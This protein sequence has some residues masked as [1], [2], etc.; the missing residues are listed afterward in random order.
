MPKGF[1]S[2]LL[3]IGR[4]IVLLILFT[5]PT[6]SQP[7]AGEYSIGKTSGNDFST[8]LQAIDSLHLKGISA[9]VKF[10][11]EPGIY[12]N[13][14]TILNI[15]GS[16][17]SNTITFESKDYDSTKVI[18]EYRSVVSNSNFC[19]KLLGAK[20]ITFSRLTFRSL[21]DTFGRVII[22]T[23]NA[24]S[25]TFKNC[26][27]EG[28]RPAGD[29][30]HSSDLSIIFSPN[31]YKSN[32]DSCM[33]YCCSFHNGSC[34]LE[35]NGNNS[36]QTETGITIFNCYFENQ[37][38]SSLLLSMQS[39]LCIYENTF[40]NTKGD[41]FN[42][43]TIYTANKGLSI[44]S[45]NFL[46]T[47]CKSGN[48]IN[49]LN[50]GGNYKNK[51]I[52]YNNTISFF[53][54]D[55]IYL[56][57]ASHDAIKLYQCD[58]L[59][60]YYN[61]FYISGKNP[62]SNIVKIDQC[63][64]LI[65]KNNILF[66]DAYGKCLYFADS[67]SS[68]FLSDNN[69]FY[70]SDDNCFFL[71][72]QLSFN[73]WKIISKNDI[74][75]LYCNPDF[76]SK[77]NLQ[78]NSLLLNNKAQAV[79]FINTD[80]ASKIRNVLFPDIGA[81]EFNPLQN[82]LA[83][84]K[85]VYPGNYFNCI[86]EDSFQIYVSLTNK[87]LDTINSF[88][89]KVKVENPD[90]FFTFFYSKPLKSLD[91]IIVLCPAYIIPKPGRETNFIVI[92]NTVNDQFSVND[93]LI[94]RMIK[95]FEIKQFPFYENFEHGLSSYFILENNTESGISID[96][97]AANNSNYGLHFQGKRLSGGW[98]GSTSGTTSENAWN[99]NLKYQANATTCNIIPDKNKHLRLNINLRQ[100]YS[101][102][103]LNSWF[104]VMLNDTH[105]LMD[106][107]STLNFN[108]TTNENKFN[109]FT[110][111]LSR[112]CDSSFTLRLQSSC[113]S[114]DSFYQEGD[115]AF[116]DNIRIFEAPKYDAGFESFV[117]PMNH[118]CSDSIVPVVVKIRNHGYDSI[119]EIPLQITVENLFYNSLFIDTI[120]AGIA[121]NQIYTHLVGYINT[122]KGG[123]FII[124][125]ILNLIGD[126]FP[127][128][129]TCSKYIYI[130][131][132]LN[133][134]VIEK[135]NGQDS[136]SNWDIKNMWISYPGHHN[137]S[138]FCLSNSIWTQE[139][140]GSAFLNKLIG[141]I[142]TQTHLGF[143]YRI[144]SNDFP[145]KARKLSDHE[146]IKILVSDNCGTSYQTLLSIDSS[147]H[148]I[149]EKMKRITIPLNTFEGKY[150]HIGFSISS[151]SFN[152]CY[153]DFDSLIV[154]D[155]PKVDAG[156]DT[157]LCQGDTII[158]NT[159][160]N[161]GF[162]Y[163]W[164]QIS[165]SQT[166]SDKSECVVTLPG[167]YLLEITSEKG[168]KN[169]DTLTVAE[170]PLPPV[171]LGSDRYVCLS[172]SVLLTASGAENYLWQNGF[173]QDKIMLPVFDTF[174]MFVIGFN[175]FGCKNSDTINIFSL[176]LPK[177]NISGP[178]SVCN[179]DTVNLISTGADHYLWSNSVISDSS[180]FKITTDTF[181]YVTGYNTFGC[182]DTAFK[183]L[184]SKTLP[185]PALGNDT[186]ICS[187]AKIIL[188][189]GIFETYYWYD[190]D[191][192]AIKTID[193]SGIGNDTL[194]AWV[195]VTKSDCLATDSIVI[196]FKDCSGVIDVSD[197]L[198]FIFPNPAKD[199][200]FINTKGEQKIISVV[201]T[202]IPG[203]I[204]WG[205]NTLVSA[206]NIEIDISS[207]LS[208][209]YILQ[210]QTN[211]NLIVK[212]IEKR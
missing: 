79:S 129:D 147:N 35:L 31:S 12:N 163:K 149:D 188:S 205:K 39:A 136:L 195:K 211:T 90:T 118:Y 52:V 3:E 145:F 186:I 56:F 41:F 139:T 48:I 32:D 171:S 22:L 5:T 44:Y 133:F 87:G 160:A 96:K 148:Q 105:Q 117:S 6:Y 29:L 122:K 177:V 164:I 208:G 184:F 182:K 14:L 86:S 98:Q 33:F 115:N 155:L 26:R 83:T 156:K 18:I 16:S 190:S 8:I 4:L 113:L 203:H 74:S 10:L 53:S 181:V 161:T 162:S 199:L 194:I 210:V 185:M 107:D 84:N 207:L 187:N 152:Q 212:K 150:I 127:E 134:P 135:F 172:D 144:V 34:A 37:F 85:I 168:W 101:F 197:A 81:F 67:M 47:Q 23:E 201:L 2:T 58:S 116:V 196:V 28:R 89:I 45:N 200:I 63:S 43:I 20:Y 17:P 108:P 178:D 128:N 124:K 175:N 54:P 9:P 166:I 104:R 146:S 21:S 173:Y 183:K 125:G 38:Y 137:A 25:D 60:I 69:C 126:L 62:S 71:Y 24:S 138:S 76:F 36:N 95:N 77:T 97:R 179:G 169:Y 176:P 78:T 180:L 11:I 151:D 40:V 82:D 157:G 142:T 57:S 72:K 174:S 15:K 119:F 143:D 121:P 93:T 202:D 153:F 165:T 80:K 159:N 209:M 55:L 140:K 46:S 30:Q 75:S 66:N 19:L 204:V 65:I 64:N 206:N 120:K 88:S 51:A 132:P 49:L 189:P 102:G 68:G 110:F 112:F 59:E 141:P 70:S 111:D 50:C 13:Q 131:T 106:I 114:Y 99:D 154:A 27:F 100:T 109:D 198:I 193:T 130:N 167:K 191:T 1:F 123:E 92:N 103:P 192:N 91:T 73:D 7:M 170:Y 94:C 158:L 61:S 42:A